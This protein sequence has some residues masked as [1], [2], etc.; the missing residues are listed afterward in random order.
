VQAVIELHNSA[1]FKKLKLC[2]EIVV[3]SISTP[4]AN[5]REPAQYFAE[6]ATD[7]YPAEAAPKVSIY[8]LRQKGINILDF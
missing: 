1:K 8:N 2:N 5:M 6:P 3:T 7:N 4:P